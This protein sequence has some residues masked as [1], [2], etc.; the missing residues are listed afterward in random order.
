MRRKS[1]KTCHSL[2]PTNKLQ[3][4]VFLQNNEMQHTLSSYS[5]RRT[6][7]LDDCVLKIITRSVPTP[8][9]QGPLTR[10]VVS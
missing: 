4:D 3:H 9:P 2:S 5:L 7:Y 10:V 1:V 8:A 6:V